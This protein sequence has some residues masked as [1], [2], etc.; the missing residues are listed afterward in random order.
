VITNRP[1]DINLK[2]ILPLGF[3]HLTIFLASVSVAYDMI[4]IGY[5]LLPG[6]PFIFTLTY[7]IQAIIAE[8]Y[9]FKIAR[10]I[11]LLTL[12]CQFLFAISITL[13]LQ[14]PH[15]SN[16]HNQDAYDV[17]FGHTIRFVTSGFFAVTCSSFLNIYLISRYKVLMDGRY[18]WL[19]TLVSSLIGGFLLVSIIILGGYLFAVGNTNALHMFISIYLLEAAYSF[20]L[21]L[22]Q[23]YIAAI[24]KSKEQMDVYDD[25]GNKQVKK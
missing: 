15:P 12:I 2:Y 7:S 3:I 4:K 14:L 17:V 6:P 18:F 9:G 22:P 11:I 24:L 10:N 19:R 16:W 1:K 23:V 5:L 20:I 21:V 13:I 25:W 8:I